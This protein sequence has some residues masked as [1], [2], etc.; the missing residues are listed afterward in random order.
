M[1]SRHIEI[2]LSILDQDLRD[3]SIQVSAGAF[4][5]DTQIRKG[6]GFKKVE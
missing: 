3:M 5:I 1:T 6:R 4:G 2:R